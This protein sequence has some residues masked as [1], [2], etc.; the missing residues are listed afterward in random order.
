MAENCFIH[1]M[2]SVNKF[3]SEERSEISKSF[4]K[5]LKAYKISGAIMKI[6][7]SASNKVPVYINVMCQQARKKNFSSEFEAECDKLSRQYIKTRPDVASKIKAL[8]K[9]VMDNAK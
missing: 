3:S 5:D 2:D 6:V 1:F 4:R 9:V 7:E 8:R